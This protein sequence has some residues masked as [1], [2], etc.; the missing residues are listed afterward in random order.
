MSQV[1][2]RL[3]SRLKLANWTL[4]VATHTHTFIITT[5]DNIHSMLPSLGVIFLSLFSLYS[6]AWARSSSGNSV[7][8]LLEPNL[9]RD[10]F[11]IFFDNLE[12]EF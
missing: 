1:E 12:S 9:S 7:L 11:T 10:N 6:A 5:R 8:V 4:R 2:G 3:N